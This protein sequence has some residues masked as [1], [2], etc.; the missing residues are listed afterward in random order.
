ML[1]FD[2]EVYL[3]F[4]MIMFLVFGLVF[5]VLVVFVVMVKFGVVIVEKLKVWCL[6]FVVG[7]FVVVVVVILLDV[8]F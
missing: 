1:V 3:F 6:Y 7:V 8:V 2:I 5:E 4:V